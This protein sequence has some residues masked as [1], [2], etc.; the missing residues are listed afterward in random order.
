MNN[1]HNVC[2][3]RIE[4]LVQVKEREAEEIE[5]PIHAEIL[6]N[7]RT[8]RPSNQEDEN[9]M[10]G[11][12]ARATNLPGE[13]MTTQGQRQTARLRKQYA[14]RLHGLDDVHIKNKES[15]LTTF[16]KFISVA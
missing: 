3:R 5:D 6:C 12:N 14:Q 7:A 15:P 9:A 11:F 13:Y 16:I 8:L 10:K 2:P 1:Q 4:E